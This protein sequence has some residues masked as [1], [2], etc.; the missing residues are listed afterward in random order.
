MHVVQLSIF[1]FVFVLG[2]WGNIMV[3]VTIFTQNRLRSSSNYFIANLAVSDL[4]ALCL[5][6]PV[7]ALHSLVGWPLGDIACRFIN[8]LKDLFLNVSMVTLTAIAVDRYLHIAHPFRTQLSFYKVKLVIVLI[9]LINYILIP[10]PMAFVMKVQTSKSAL[11][12]CQPVWS[13]QHRRIAIICLSS[14]IFM[15]AG[16]TALAYL[17]VGL[18]LKQQRKRIVQRA[19]KSGI[20]EKM[21]RRQL[22]KN[23]KTLKVMVVIVVA[24]W[25]SALPLTLYGLLSEL[26]VLKMS[27]DESSLTFFVTVTLLLLPNSMNPIILYVVSREMRSGFAACVQCRT[28]DKRMVFSQSRKHSLQSAGKMCTANNVGHQRR[29]VD[30]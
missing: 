27:G 13:G 30:V 21:Y 18:A 11:K 28:N 16:I 15:F 19:R 24:F 7:A 25:F 23:A 2:I 9:W 29:G 6:L 10:L 20:Q 1:A 4:G 17:G 3:I 22:E 14:F 12:L 5:S 8:P 26:K